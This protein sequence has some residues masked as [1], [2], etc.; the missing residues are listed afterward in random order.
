MTN[1]NEVLPGWWLPWSATWDTARW[2]DFTDPSYTRALADAP[3]V[4]QLLKFLD[5][6][7]PDRRAWAA[8]LGAFK[9]DKPLRY[10]AEFHGPIADRQ[11]ETARYKFLVPAWRRAIV[12]VVG[13]LD[14]IED[15]ISTILWIMEWITKKIIPIP[16]T[17]MNNAQRLQRT[18]DCAEKIVAGITPFRFTKT[19]HGDC[20]RK[21]NESKSGARQR[22]AGLLAWFR[23]NW[24]RI[25]EAAQAT[26]TW[27]DVGIVLGPIMGYIEEGMWGIAQQTL[28][29]Y[30]IAAESVMPGYKLA[31]EERA[32]TMS[33]QVD[34]AFDSTWGAVTE[35]TTDQIEKVFPLPTFSN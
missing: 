31:F 1:W 14:D 7:R 20:L 28:N 21:I 29:N 30:L 32:A 3:D 25:L 26:D 13:E 15:Q 22:K 9:N 11:Y 24:G 23:D 8:W 4:S 19:E 2:P 34:E 35:W 16:P 17:V 10:R 33:K 12:E 18:L 6:G 27:F 5:F